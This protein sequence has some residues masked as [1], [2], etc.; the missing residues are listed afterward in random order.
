MPAEVMPDTGTTK[1]WTVE[2]VL[3]EESASDFQISPDGRWAVWVK[4][5]IDKEKGS[6]P[7]TGP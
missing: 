3:L 5:Q 6:G 2:D 1:K 7:R 4:R